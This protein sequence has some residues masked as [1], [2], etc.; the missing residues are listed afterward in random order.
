MSLIYNHPSSP[1]IPSSYPFPNCSASKT[2]PAI[3]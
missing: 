3:L 1:H 2:S